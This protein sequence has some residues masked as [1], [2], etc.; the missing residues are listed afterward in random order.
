MLDYIEHIAAESTFVSFGPGEF[1]L[2][3]EQEAAFVRASLDS[4]NRLFL[5]GFVEDQLVGSINIAG[6]LRARTQH[7]GEFGMSVRAAHW[8]RGI[9]T[10]LL[11]D[12][13][14]WAR[15]NV[16]LTR[17]ALRVRSDN[18]RAIALYER[19]GFDREG[20]L[21]GD[22]VVDGVSYDHIVMALAV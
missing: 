20:V 18:H 3:V 6:G 10:Y 8:H 5:L 22:F 11:A 12:L 4:D 16:V 17:V 21:R 14:E 15:D 9:G 1:G 2:T 7:S 19:F 13:L